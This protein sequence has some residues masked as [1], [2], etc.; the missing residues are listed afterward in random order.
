VGAS[1]NE[2]LLEVQIAG[3][4]HKF[5]IDS[6]A[7]LSLV[8]PGVSRAEVRPMDLAARGITGTKLRSI[9]TQEIELKLGNC[10]Y[11]HEFLV[12]SLDVEYSGVFGLDILRQM[13]AKVDPCSSGLIIGQR[14]YALAGLNNQDCGAPLVTVA[15]PV[16]KDEWSTSG[17]INPAGS[18]RNGKASGEPGMGGLAW[19][20]GN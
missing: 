18:T 9:G 7:S 4:S 14:R 5:L 20:A 3:E 1:G 19:M 13:Q 12:T 8:K 10:V 16:A 15:K 11:T 6:G 2:L 17:L